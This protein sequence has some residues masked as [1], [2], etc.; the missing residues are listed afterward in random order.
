M[1]VSVGRQSYAGIASHGLVA[2]AHAS[3]VDGGFATKGS[4]VLRSAALVRQRGL[5]LAAQSESPGLS[6]AGLRAHFSQVISILHEQS[7]KSLVVAVERLR[8]AHGDGWSRTERERWSTMLRVNRALQIE[9][10]RQYARRGLFPINEHHSSGPIPIFVDRHDTACAVG[11]L[12]RES[13]CSDAVEEIARRNNHVYVSDVQDGLLV[14]WVLQSGLTQEEAALI[15][16]AYGPSCQAFAD[17]NL[18]GV[19]DG[20]DAEVRDLSGWDFRGMDLTGAF[21]P[22]EFTWPCD[23]NLTGANLSGQNLANAALINTTLTGAILTDAVVTGAW[24]NTSLGFTKEQ[25]Y[26]TASYRAMDLQGIGLGGDLHHF[27]PFVS[28]LAGWDFA[29]QNL[30]SAR[31]DRSDLS[32]TDFRGANLTGADLGEST[33]TNAD[34]T[35]AVIAGAYLSSSSSE[36]IASG[37]LTREQ[38]YS[39][40]SYQAK[41]L[42]GIG[43]P[44]SD[45]G[46]WDF[47]GQNLTSAALYGSDLS[48]ADFSGANLTKAFFSRAALTNANLTGADTRGA[49][50]LNLTNA[51]ARNSILPNGRIK[52]LE[53]AAGE[54]MLVRDYDGVADSSSELP[55]P[56]TIE[57]HLRTA[58]GS[59]LELLFDADPWDSLVLFE[60]GIPVQLDGAL[61]LTFANDVDV[62][63]QVGRNLRL[64]N[65]TGVSPSG[66]FEI[67]S[68]Y[69]WDVNNL[70]TTGEV[71]LIAVPEPSA[72]SILFVGVLLLAACCRFTTTRLRH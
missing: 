11:H 43:L 38:I 4:S 72:T 23:Y 29:G 3:L 31:L 1:L 8:K 45:L 56:V 67:R 37:G 63:T 49:Y 53:L 32:E 52:G 21:D 59:I 41:D 66:Q 10:L 30:T 62:A 24:F 36:E 42:R 61:E 70:Y 17:L 47:S 2:W 35:G 12:M 15:Q 46:G 13:G 54:K 9:R 40:A 14:E 55:I 25:L 68:P 44:E 65:W 27:V 71:R 64:F 26:S 16:P 57:D 50:N 5:R 69:I 19:V 22:M 34:F 7:E 33:L 51:V 39:T 6:Q 28:D 60:H 58:E 48:E 20:S 18:D